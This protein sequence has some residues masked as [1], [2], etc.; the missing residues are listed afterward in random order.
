MSDRLTSAAR[1]IFRALV[2]ALLLFGAVVVVCFWAAVLTA[3]TYQS[4]RETQ[5]ARAA[6]DMLEHS[7]NLQLALG[8]PVTE[9]IDGLEARS[10][11]LAG[12]NGSWAVVARTATEFDITV[13][14]EV[15]QEYFSP[16][17][18][19]RTCIRLVIDPS[20]NGARYSDRAC[21]RHDA[22]NSTRVIP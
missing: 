1:L 2:A 17:L 19:G 10:S 21:G 5:S 4:H 11:P 15:E 3:L 20:G 12:S 7:V 14:Y 16:Q 22:Q 13:L 18:R 8:R 9:V 6:A